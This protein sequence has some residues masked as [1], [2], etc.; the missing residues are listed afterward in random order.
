[1][2]CMRYFSKIYPCLCSYNN[3]IVLESWPSLRATGFAFITWTNAWKAL[4]ALGIGDCIRQEHGF[5]DGAVII[6][7]VSGKPV[8]HVSYKTRGTWYNYMFE[9]HT[10]HCSKL[11]K[12]ADFE[13]FGL[14]CFLRFGRRGDHEGSFIEDLGHFKL[15]HL[16]DGTILKTKGDSKFSLFSGEGYRSGFL[17]CD[18]S[19]V[20]WYFS[21]T[22]DQVFKEELQDNPAKMKQFVLSKLENVP[23][24]I[25][26][27]VELTELDNLVLS[28]L[29]Y[30]RSWEVLLGNISKGNVCVAGDALHP[31]TPDLGQGGCSALEDGVV[32]A[33]CLGKAL[34]RNSSIGSKEEDMEASAYKSIQ[35][36]LKTYAK[37]RRRRSFDLITTAYLVGTIQQSSGA[38]MTFVRDA[39][40]ATWLRGLPLKKADF[41]CGKIR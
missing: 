2:R 27:F 35:T 38:V 14:N 16:A 21:W 30:R 37:E 26:K 1:M 41:D 28:P 17:P 29:V 13:F 39:L 24:Q 3:S 19:T 11:F 6:S 33:R 31:M 34:L 7:T 32:L 15:V 36:G 10:D 18:A 25:R 8:G 12:L 20:F 5:I 22:P 4:D 9:F 23:D 40:L